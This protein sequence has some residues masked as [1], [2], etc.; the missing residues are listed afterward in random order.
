MARYII[1]ENDSFKAIES[2]NIPINLVL[3]EP[4]KTWSDNDYT[5]VNNGIRISWLDYYN[6]NRWKC[7]T[8]N[9][10]GTKL[11]EINGVKK[12]QVVIDAL[13]RFKFISFEELEELYQKALESKK[14][15][16]EL[17][18]EKLKKDQIEAKESFSEYSEILKK[19]K[20]IFVLFE[21][22]NNKK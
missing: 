13:N 18:I 6:D 2:E 14:S 9:Y 4:N 1:V 12:I 20:E 19:V 8:I 17:E 22:L 5:L 3:M 16:L 11:I 15:E 7:L 10:K 21:N